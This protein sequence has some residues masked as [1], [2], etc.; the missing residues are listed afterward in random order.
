MTTLKRAVLKSY[1]SATHR[2][3]VQIAGSLSVWLEG[4]LVATDI[5]AADCV[6][7]RECAVLFFTDDN[8]DDAVVLCVY[9]AL[10]SG[11]GGAATIIVQE[12]DI[13]IEAAATTLDF[14]EPDA[15]LVTSA[16]AGEANIN[17]ALYA[18]LGGRSGGQTIAGSP[19]AAQVL[20]LRGNT[21]GGTDHVVIH[22]NAYL[23]LASD[24]RGIIDSGDNLR[25][26]FNATAN[27]SA[28]ITGNLWVSIPALS[29]VGGFGAGIIPVTH[30]YAALGN[31]GAVGDS[32]IGCLVDMGSS[33][34]APGNSVIGVAGRALGRNSGTLSALGLDYI[35]GVGSG[36]NGLTS[37]YGMRSAALISNASAT[38]EYYGV[39]ARGATLISGSLT[40]WYGF[41]TETPYIGTDRLPFWEDVAD[42]GD[43]AG[44]RFK[45][46]TQFASTVG[47]FGGGNG[48]L[49]LANATTVPSSNPSGGGILYAEAGAL[50]WRGSGG[51]VTTL[52]A[53]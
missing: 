1:T 5:P 13:T 47:A 3:S 28:K 38:L 44:N 16:P 22:S 41:K 2:A 7:G 18:L 11:G 19:T 45:S 23:K 52:A 46:N 20:T 40:K 50:K 34:G 6:A 17:M 33:T 24:L 36:A 12:G 9:N 37:A 21:F 10:P 49:G 39:V 53:A 30:A 25:L 43:G 35:A 48:V 51:T 8:P 15:A 42:T 32:L 26:N 14:T 4:I 27:P 31:T 29:T